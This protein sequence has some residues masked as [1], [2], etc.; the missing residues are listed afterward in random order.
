MFDIHFCALDEIERVTAFIDIYWSKDHVLATSRMLMDWQHKEDKRYNFVIATDGD[1]T[2]GILGFIPTRRYDPELEN[3]IWL[4]IWKARDDIPGL[5][6]M[7]L[8]YLEKNEPRVAI[9]TV[10]IN[11][12]VAKLYRALGYQVG[13]LNHYYIFRE[14]LARP[15]ALK[16]I[17]RSFK[18][19]LTLHPETVPQKSQRYLCDR[20]MRH[21]VYRYYL[22]A[23]DN[24]TLIIRRAEAGEYSALRIVDY[25]GR[26][27]LLIHFPY[28][29]L[30]HAYNVNL[31]DFYNY[32]I[33]EKIFEE[34][35]FTKN[36]GSVV[37]PN[38]YEPL[39]R[40]NVVLQF[41]YKAE[42]KLLIFKGD[43]DQDRPNMIGEE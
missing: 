42:G 33:D 2:L 41:A 29:A 38:Y 28:Q 23:W 34:A 11:D 35:G 18:I 24:G 20:Y 19:P 6:L 1:E 13:T 36:D 12:E 7:L 32:G 3:T 15:L 10:G 30:M 27:E 17:T 16:E 21:P 8:N 14:A 9:G 4:A 39:V 31:I 37:I 5:G 26:D 22:Y 40:R 25:Y 43:A